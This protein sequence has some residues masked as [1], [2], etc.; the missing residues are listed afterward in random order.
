M[1]EAKVP[2]VTKVRFANYDKTTKGTLRW[3]EE[4]LEDKAVFRQ[5]YVTKESIPQDVEDHPEEYC[6]E[7]TIKIFKN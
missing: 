4:I 1:P 5:I 7:V 2:I 3:Q 6:V